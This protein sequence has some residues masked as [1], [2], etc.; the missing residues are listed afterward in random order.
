MALEYY[1]GI[2]ITGTSTERTGGTFT[3]L[4]IGWL[5][6]ET[7]TRN[8]YR[9]NGTAWDTVS[10]PSGG[11]G[12]P[13]GSA[14]GDLTGTYPNP[15]VDVNKIDNTKVAD[16]AA[17]SIKGNATASSA[18]PTDIAIGTNTVLG[19]VGSNIVAAGLVGAQVTAATITYA[20]I[21]NISAT[22]RILGRITAG[23]GVMEELT[24]TQLTT[25]LDAFTSALKGLVPASGGGTTNFLRADGTWVAIPPAEITGT[26]TGSANGSSTVFNIAHGL[27]ATPYCAFVQ[28]SSV[29]GS[30]IFYSF[31]YDS[32][33]IVVTFA[34]APT[35]GS[36]TFQ[37][38]VVA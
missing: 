14:G 35:T 38:R 19:R 1:G 8:I 37:W 23:A 29:L 33:N 13:T 34:S 11:G 18:D 16:M 24:G 15:T 9:W 31:T 6:L 32:T 10:T 5:F 28:V 2:I 12:P 7:D 36:V 25:L 26:A 17:N 30:N 3:N 22:A 20:K 4:T 27:G 21:Q